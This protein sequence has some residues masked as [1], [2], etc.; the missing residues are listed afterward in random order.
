MKLLLDHGGNPNATDTEKW[1]PL[2]A[3]ATCGHLHL[4]KFL[5]D[6]DADLLAVNA[7][8]NMPYDLCE[9]DTTLS[10]IENEMAKRGVTQELIDDTRALTERKMLRDLQNA[11]GDALEGRDGNSGATPLHVAAAN[12]YLTVVEYLLDNH[13]STESVDN[14]LWQPIHAAACWGHL[15][16]V[17]MLA[18]NGANINAKTKNGETP[19]DICEDPEIK[20]RLI[21][22]REA[23]VRMGQPRV[24]RSHSASTRT[25]SIRRTSLREK[26][27]TTKKDVQDEKV[28]FMQSFAASEKPASSN[29]QVKKATQRHLTVGDRDEDDPVD[30]DDVKLTI[31]PSY[32]D[33]AV[34]PTEQPDLPPRR[35]PR[36]TASR[37]GKFEWLFFSLSFWCL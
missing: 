1:T 8:G 7:D 13:V 3:A 4:V 32:E 22:L 6:H 24:R 27:N 23:R 18:Q 21:Q 26:M 37:D 15:E 31:V 25:Q 34:E 9:D 20:E 36:S 33:R 35:P 10:Y 12:G 28:F 14:D 17:E 16:V 29:Q 30:I 19:F 5:I 11:G 2:H